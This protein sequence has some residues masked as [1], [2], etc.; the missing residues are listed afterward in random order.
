MNRVTMNVK[1]LMGFND[2]SFWFYEGVIYGEP[3][4]IEIAVPYP[5]VSAQAISIPIGDLAS[6]WW[7]MTGV[8]DGEMA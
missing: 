8:D 3:H 2:I 5:W 1:G 7:R 4:N 6:N